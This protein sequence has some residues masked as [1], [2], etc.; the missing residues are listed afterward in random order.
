MAGFH[1]QYIEPS[2]FRKGEYTAL[3]GFSRFRIRRGIVEGWI[4]QET[5]PQTPNIMPN[6]KRF[7]ARTLRQLEILLADHAKEMQKVF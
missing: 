7:F 2:Y 1:G 6:G 4:A 3:A 5:I